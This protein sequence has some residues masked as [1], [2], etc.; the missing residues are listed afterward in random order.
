MSV[1]FHFI[2]FSFIYLLFSYTSVQLK[3][4]FVMSV[5]LCVSCFDVQTRLRFLRPFQPSAVCTHFCT[6]AMTSLYVAVCVLIRV[7]RGCPHVPSRPGT[8][9]IPG[10]SHE[11]PSRPAPHRQQHWCPMP[12]VLAPVVPAAAAPLLVQVR[13]LEPLLCDGNSPARLIWTSSRNAQRA[14]FSLQDFQHRSGRE[15]YSSS[16]YAMDLLSVAL[17]KKLNPRVRRPGGLP[18]PHGLC[19]RCGRRAPS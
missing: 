1:L 14:N 8:R 18:R 6:G 13:E 3:Q 16:K 19:P 10:P 17:N 12:S 7:N 5:W 2:L 9:V 4:L 15:P 11:S